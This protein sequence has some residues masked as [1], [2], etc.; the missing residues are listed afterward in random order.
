MNI[1][2]LVILDLQNQRYR[3]VKETELTILREKLDKYVT[4]KTEWDLL[5][6]CDKNQFGSQFKQLRESKSITVA[7][8]VIESGL[9]E[10]NIR[11]IELGHRK[12]RIET[13][14]TLIT[15]LKTLSEK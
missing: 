12:P 5:L 4:S 9:L 10:P 7:Q 11:N 14:K 3:L 2:E 1:E 6:S 13:R 15:A 8:I